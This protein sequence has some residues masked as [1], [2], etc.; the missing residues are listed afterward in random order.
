MRCGTFLLKS[1]F[2]EA[3]PTNNGVRFERPP[4]PFYY[5][6]PPTLVLSHRTLRRFELHGATRRK[7]PTTFNR[8]FPVTEEAY[9]YL[10]TRGWLY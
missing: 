10:T 8:T 2:Y 9:Y 1:A 3:L 5:S 6:T 7:L 4:L